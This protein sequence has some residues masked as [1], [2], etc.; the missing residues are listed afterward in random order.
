MILRSLPPLWFFEL[1]SPSVS[2]FFSFFFFF[3]QCLKTSLHALMNLENT[4]F[5]EARRQPQGQLRDTALPA[6]SPNFGLTFDRPLTARSKENQRPN[7]E[8]ETTAGKYL[9]GKKVH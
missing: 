8:A 7:S 5:Q 3:L 2:F 6:A 9:R 4:V 1:L